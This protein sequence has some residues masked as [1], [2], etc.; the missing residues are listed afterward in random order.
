MTNT[1]TLLR[2]TKGNHALQKCSKG[3]ANGGPHAES[4]GGAEPGAERR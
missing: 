1:T 4:V 3:R 2:P